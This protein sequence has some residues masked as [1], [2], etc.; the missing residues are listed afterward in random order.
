MKINFKTKW[1][2]KAK[3]LNVSL[4]LTER[5]CHLVIIENGKELINVKFE[6]RGHYYGNGLEWYVFDKCIEGEY[7]QLKL[8]DEN[9]LF[10]GLNKDMPILNNY[11]KSFYLMNVS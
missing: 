4:I 5:L 11:Y 3:N 2:L 1:L 8:V 10:V 6:R 7:L 9:N